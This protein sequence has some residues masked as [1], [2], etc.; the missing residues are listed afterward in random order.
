LLIAALGAWGTLWAS[1]QEEEI[2]L[3]RTAAGQLK[4]QVEFTQPLPLPLSVYPGITGYATANVGLH[5][6]VFDDPTNDFSQPSTSADFQF[7]LVAKDPGMEVWNDTGSGYMRTGES[8]FIG[9]PP[10]DN[11]PVWNLPGS[12]PGIVYSLTLRFHDSNAVYPDSAPVILRFTPAIITVP[13]ILRQTAS[14]EV[15]ISWS[16]NAPG[17][18]LEAAAAV[19]PAAWNPVTN[20]VGLVGTNFSVNLTT[21]GAQQYF[22]LRN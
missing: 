11:H 17:G 9:P 18:T 22:R 8:Y 1:A 5:S 13:L 20:A 19:A 15:T 10:F 16:T 4:I 7:I 21:A 2:H 12:S 3:G 6:T 14:N